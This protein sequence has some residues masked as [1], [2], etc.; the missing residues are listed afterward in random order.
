[1]ILPTKTIEGG[2][3]CASKESVLTFFRKT[4]SIVSDIRIVHFL[5]VS[6]FWTLT[7]FPI[8]LGKIF[9]Q[10]FAKKKAMLLSIDVLKKE[11]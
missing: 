2:R 6:S 11:V 7:A 4:C 9:L 5:I 3:T 1:M 10:S 8:T